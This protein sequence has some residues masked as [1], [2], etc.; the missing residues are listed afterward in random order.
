MFFIEIAFSAQ[1]HGAVAVGSR[2]KNELN[3]RSRG[4]KCD[5]GMSFPAAILKSN[6][7][8]LLR[9]ISVA[10]IPDLLDKKKIIIWKTEVTSRNV[11]NRVQNHY[12]DNQ[13]EWSLIN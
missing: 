1:I 9:S 8:L 3:I 10:C 2:I 6:L 11:F 5:F 12:N 7:S 4:D 13:V